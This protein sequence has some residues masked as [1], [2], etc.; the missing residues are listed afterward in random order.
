MKKRIS[1]MFIAA[2]MI[3]GVTAAASA[4]QPVYSQTP[5]IT[6]QPVG[7]NYLLNATSS[8]LTVEAH[9][10]DGG[11]LTYQWY[12]FN[13]YKITTIEGAVGSS[14]T[15]PTSESGVN[16]YYVIVTNINGENISAAIMSI[17][18]RVGVFAEF[19]PLERITISPGGFSGYG[20]QLGSDRQFLAII[21]PDNVTDTSVTW[22]SSNP[23]VATVNETGVVTAVS[24]G[25]VTIRATANDGSGIYGE[26][27]IHTRS[28]GTVGNPPRSRSSSGGGGSS[29]GSSETLI[30][31]T[32]A[33]APP[34]VPEPLTTADALNILK[35]AAG[36]ITL[37][38]AQ[39]KKYDMD[40]DGL[41]T[42]ADAVHVLRIVAGIGEGY[43]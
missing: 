5:I 29:G 26:F 11:T 18:V 10:T 43:V 41:I 25:A 21:T 20:F 12:S 33:P 40:G 32:P 8:S 42:S 23:A 30:T 27:T 6:A 3:L 37:T 34:P 35:A 2:V 13:N 15:P 38:D 39:V 4:S 36:L 1:A 28:A 16:Y 19:A 9:V 31:P 17:A 14:F 7:A 22:S 24:A